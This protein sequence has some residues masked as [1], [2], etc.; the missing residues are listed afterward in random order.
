M[1]DDARIARYARQLLVPG[2]G[3][4]AQERLLASRVRVVGAD[5]VASVAM[6]QLAQAGVGRLWVEDAAAVTG[7]DLVGWLYSATSAGTPRAPA[8]CAAVN[9]ASSYSIAEPYPAGGVPTAALI[10]STLAAQALVA[11][12]AA[13]RAAA[14]HVVVEPDA[15]GGAVVAVPPDAPCYACARSA[16]RA[17]RAATGG[18]AAT[19]GALA[20]CELLQ[21]IA[22]PAEH[23]GRRIEVVRGVVVA[24]PTARLPG[25]ACGR[26]A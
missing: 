5:A 19:L 24:R 16:S 4:A 26:G 23:A 17:G 3:E 21:M 22:M 11:A 2:F 14:P 12:E 15:D 10:A 20:A 25:C 8:A 6:I 1:L 9:A 7:D 18:A 13:R